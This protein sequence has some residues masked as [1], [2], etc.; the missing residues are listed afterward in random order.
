MRLDFRI[1]GP[2]EALVDG[3]PA[4]LGGTRQRAV[5]ALLLAHANKVVPVEQLIDAVW[6]DAPPETAANVLQGY[7]SHLR[8][9]LGRR[10]IVTRGRGYAAVVPD[11]AL[12][13]H[14]FER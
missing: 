4:T 1:L 3:V 8:K 11:G 13:L 14:R 2:V 6:D 5:L 10:A 7:V 12:D 9:V